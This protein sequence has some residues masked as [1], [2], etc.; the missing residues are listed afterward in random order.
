MAVEA[1]ETRSL[2]L[3]VGRYAE[4]NWRG[5][6]SPKV[7]LADSYLVAGSYAAGKALNDGGL[8][9]E[10]EGQI[11]RHFGRQDHWEFNLPLALRWQRFPWSRWV[12]TS[13]ALGAGPSYAT[14]RPRLELAL[15][16]S[17]QQWMLYWFADLTLG[18]P[19]S[20]WSL[21]MRLHHRS[22]A[23]GVFGEEG[24]SNLLALGVRRSF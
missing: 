4:N 17:T 5:A 23:Y 12:S 9:L 16:G 24:G 8:S 19:T 22:T 15:Q 13:L 21:L 20:A 18:P 6:V 1:P 7:D 3:Y 10:L 2:M 14:Q 11:V